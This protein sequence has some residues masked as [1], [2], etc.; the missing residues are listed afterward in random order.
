MGFLFLIS[1]SFVSAYYGG[2]WYSDP[3]YGFGR[4]VEQIIEFV[5]VTFGPFFEVILGGY[6]DYLFERVMFLAI[7]LA[8]IYMIT[9]K[10]EVFKE[11][12]FVVW[13]VT[14]AVSLL[15]IRFL[16]DDMISTMLLPYNV[17]GVAISAVLPLIIYFSFVESFTDSPTMRKTLWL[18]FMVAFIGIWGSRYETLGDLSW[19]YFFTA[20]AALIFL[21]ADGT[22]QNA[23][24]K[25]RRARLNVLNKAQDIA[26]VRKE[27]SELRKYKKD[28]LPEHFKQ[29]EKDK[30][31]LIERLVKSKY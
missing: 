22:I 7:L 15:S 13:T 31:E 19:I 1:L 11:N 4:G 29:I 12:K 28:Y 3:I 17:V 24:M 23:L 20:I 18:F 5:E 27:L 26:L 14:I 2:G 25:Q 10:M 6:R 30:M 8:V 16:S 9:S 21:L